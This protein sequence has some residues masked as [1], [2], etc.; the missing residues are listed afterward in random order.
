M[1]AI[2]RPLPATGA[3]A[4]DGTVHNH[5]LRLVRNPYFRQWSADARPD[6]YPNAIDFRFDAGQ[7]EVVRAVQRGTADYA[8]GALLGAPRSQV[9]ATFARYAGRVH[10]NRKPGF[11][12]VFMNSRVPPFDNVDVRRALNYAVDRRAIAELNGGKK[13]V[14]PTCQVLPPDFPSYRP[15]CPYTRDARHGAPW[16]APDLKRARHLVARSH[17][18]GMRVTVWGQHG[19]G[20]AN[21]LQERSITR[22][23]DRLGYR[24]RLQLLPAD[25]D[26]SAYVQDSRHRAQVGLGDWEADYPAPGDFLPMLFSCA[27]FT[28]ADKNQLNVS[29]Y[30]DPT[31]DRL[32]GH[33]SALQAAGRASDAA[34]AWARADRRIVDQAASVPLASLKWVDF[35]SQRVGDFQY[36]PE[37]GVLLD[38]LWVR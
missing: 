35:V 24:A 8:L 11:I 6:G 20:A 10:D 12:Y 38:Q 9:D 4:F 16:S 14:E 2:R 23:L 5:R 19:T 18:I 37:F 26:F 34:A 29:E 17:T 25:A 21:I 7:Q 32:I 31:T 3:Y 27:A 28:P 15:Y 13:L 1:S 22:V 33:A 36:S 30:C